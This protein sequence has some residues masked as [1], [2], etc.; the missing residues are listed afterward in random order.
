MM[1]AVQ[2]FRYAALLHPELDAVSGIY[3]ALKHLLL[4]SKLLFQTV[5][6]FSFRKS[7]AVDS[8]AK[9]TALL[10]KIMSKQN[11]ALVQDTKPL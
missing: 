8:T 5:P 1:F 9:P 10:M 4:S 2:I 6:Q 7:L 11:S 3:C